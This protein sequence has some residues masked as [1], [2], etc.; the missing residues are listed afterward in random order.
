MGMVLGHSKRCVP[1]LYVLIAF[2]I[3]FQ[4]QPGTAQET[5]LLVGD[6]GKDGVL[7]YDSDTRAFRDGWGLSPTGGLSFLGG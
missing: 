3:A 6:R 5:Q 1:I 7:V 4:A 2:Y